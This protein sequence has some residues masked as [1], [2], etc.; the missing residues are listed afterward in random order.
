M[1]RLGA[2]SQTKPFL[3]SEARAGKGTP[4]GPPLADFHLGTLTLPSGVMT[5]PEPLTWVLLLLTQALG[6]LSPVFLFELPFILGPEQ[7]GQRQV[8]GPCPSC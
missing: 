7:L 8:N 5:T 3:V 4:A 1:P 6:H 2:I